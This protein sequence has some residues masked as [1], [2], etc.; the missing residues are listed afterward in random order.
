MADVAQ[1]K[2]KLRFHVFTI[3]VLCEASYGVVARK[4]YAR[5]AQWEI[6]LPA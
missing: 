2:N 3:K 1:G 4:S 5:S 6:T